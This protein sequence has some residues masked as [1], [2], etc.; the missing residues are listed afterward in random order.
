MKC[1]A[2]INL[3]RIRL[4]VS[5]YLEWDS[6]ARVCGSPR[7]IDARWKLTLEACE[8]PAPSRKPYFTRNESS[9]PKMP[10]KICCNILEKRSRFVFLVSSSSIEYREFDA[11]GRTSTDADWIRPRVDP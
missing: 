3:P 2:G 7:R 11:D 9:M 10:L 6:P 8:V 1:G 4:R 5:R